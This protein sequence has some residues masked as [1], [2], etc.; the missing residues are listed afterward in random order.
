MSSSIS[1]LFDEVSHGSIPTPPGDALADAAGDVVLDCLIIGPA[2]GEATP[3][4]TVAPRSI[5]VD[6]QIKDLFSLGEEANKRD[7]R[8]AL[9]M[10]LTRILELD[11]SNAVAHF[12][13]GVLNRDIKA[14]PVAE[15]NFRQAI[16]HDP[17][18][19]LYHL[20]LGE[21]M[22]IMRHLL[23]AAEAY[24]NGLVVDP[25]NMEMLINL[26]DVRQKQ[27]MPQQVADLSRRVLALNP[28]SSAAMIKLGWALLWLDQAAE[29]ADVAQRA[30]LIEPDSLQAMVVLQVATAR[31]GRQQEAAAM[32]AKIEPLAVALWNDCAVVAEAFCNL[33]E[34]ATAERLLQLVVDRQPNFV[35]ALQQL[36]RM[37][38][39]KG[40]LDRSI[41]LMS[42]V[43]ELDPNQGDAQTSISLT[44]IARGE[45]EAGWAR[46]H[47]RWQRSGCEPRWE[48]PMPDWDGQKID[49]GGLLIWREQGIGDMVMY[50][51][52]AIAC[53]H[54]AKRVVIETNPR[55]RALLQ[56]SFP[57]MLVICRE[58]LPADFFTQHNILAHCANGDLPHLL[59]LDMADYPGRDGFLTAHPSTV[60][61]LRDRYRLLFP[62]K[63]LVGI[64]WR[65]GN[66]SSATIRS[67]DL[68]LWM[69]IF[70]TP[71]CAFISLQ[72]GDI[73][74]DV[75]LLRQDHGV[76]VYIDADVNAMQD[77]DRFAAQVAA[78]DV[79]ISV[80][81]STVHVAG[82]LGKTTWALI[83]SAPDWRWLKRDRRDTIWY[84][85]VTLLRQE[86]GADWTAPVQEAA[87]C[88]R[89]FTAE[90]ATTERQALASRC[91]LQSYQYRDL[92]T[93]ELYF[94][95]I[96]VENQ[97]HHPAL[98]GL[99]RIAME[100][101]HFE[102]AIGWLRRAVDVTPHSADYH[103]DL[104]KA[105]H[106]GGRHQQA[107]DTLRLGLQIDGTDTDA[108][109]LGIE[110]LR[111]LGN[112]DEA[113]NYCA[114]LLR[115]NPGHREA[116]LHLAQMQASD[117]NFDVAEANFRRVV[118]AH[119]DDVTAKFSLGCLDLRRG[120]LTAGWKGYARRFDAGLPRP[121]IDLK[122]TPLAEIWQDPG[123]LKA[124]RVAV[125]AEPGLKDQI[126][127]MRWLSALRHDANF[128]AAELDPRLIPLIDQAA[129]RVALFPAGS[130]QEE[131]ASDLDLSAELPLGD[132]AGRYGLD[133]KR[134]GDAVP[135][136][137][138]DQAKAISLRQ[139]YLSALNADRLIGICWRGGDIAIPLSDWM[140]VL[141]T[142]GSGFVSLQ[143]GPAQQEMHDVFD[144]MN[145]AAVRDP[146]I[147]PQS[148]LRGY[149][150]QIAAVDLVIS[151]DEV[152][153]H[154]AG[155]LG[156]PTIC[157]L[158][159]VTDWR[160]FE[161]DRQDSP[162]YPTLRL[163]RQTVDGDWSTVMEKIASDLAELADA[164]E[165]TSAS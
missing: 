151:I 25:N 5:T 137:Q 57:D 145:L 65:S 10:H 4:F 24:E 144:S 54:L 9:R 100:T 75:E 83:P 36:G 14:Y 82:A 114:R 108:L 77:M 85:S 86:P 88:L 50:A 40:D 35:P 98:A 39:L 139:A 158:P 76:E 90:I 53:R 52:P 19:P 66:S 126:M 110:I 68:P 109:T 11:P 28:Q 155:A 156:V 30:L 163:Y 56:R 74:K 161:N 148:N 134:L 141:R 34:N 93:A 128:V 87:E 123:A 154:L 16:K 64:S 104:A 46:H 60:L 42:K 136:L 143:A 135:Y 13:I 117:G 160:W 95:Q 130:L 33:D 7:D 6:Q 119:P 44:L 38:V 106:A 115:L 73:S 120:N 48:L 15:A 118:E 91:A 2:D 32:F 18:R 3:D 45:Y 113:A 124:A 112:A 1:L 99:G 105:L 127:F 69:P 101:G 20:A 92:N 97:N 133:V 150:A 59:K 70:E 165:R 27:R 129:M 29:A 146:L 94:R 41:E 149:A 72:Y 138:F 79:V 51:A 49:D 26:A 159:R 116:R 147:D 111:H 63:Q 80:D 152:P 121:Q 47:W 157:L 17:K 31:L 162:W 12:N 58:D 61:Q 43:V 89:H 107:F 21:L 67:I 140:P 84:R 132:L 102:D 37:M 96:L 55:L 71:D 78:L 122:L 164:V 125:R 103:R 81:N 62:G 153:V 142:S 23:F 131:E 8:A 22:Q